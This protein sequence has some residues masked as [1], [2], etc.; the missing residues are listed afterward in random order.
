VAS[1]LAGGGTP[2]AIAS[3]VAAAGGFHTIGLLFSGLGGIAGHAVGRIGSAVARAGAKVTGAASRLAR[4]GSLT[5]AW[6]IRETNWAFTPEAAAQHAETPK[7]RSLAQAFQLRAQELAAVAANP[8][9]AQKAI[10]D[11]LTPLRAYAPGVADELEMLSISVPLYL[12]DKMPKDP[13]TIQRMGKSAW[14]PSDYEI[15]QWGE[16]VRG[17]IA[18][19]DVIEEAVGYGRITPQAA[20]AVRTL[21]PELFARTQFEIITHADELRDK[22]DHQS[23]VRLSILFDAPITSTMRPEFRQFMQERYQLRAQQSGGSSGSRSGGGPTAAE[24][25]TGPQQLLQQ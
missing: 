8:D 12:A 15:L 21:H 24:P 22:L 1:K 3:G 13:G 17:A 23:Q 14:R 9:A 19:L 7:S 11:E 16:H 20:E 2:G 4:P 25:M 6:L 5:A 18:P 10:H